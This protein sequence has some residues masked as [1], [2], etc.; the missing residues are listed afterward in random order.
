MP[1]LIHYGGLHGS[2]FIEKLKK[3]GFSVDL[4]GGGVY[5]LK[6][7]EKV[8]DDRHYTLDKLAGLPKD[9]LKKVKLSYIPSIEALDDSDILFRSLANMQSFE[10]FLE[11]LLLLQKDTI[12][13]SLYAVFQ[14][15]VNLKEGS[16]YGFEALCRGRISIT[17]LVEFAKPL[18]ETVDWTCREDALKKKAAFKIPADVKLFLNFFPE[19]LQNTEKA[20]KH[21]F[22]LLED[23]KISPNEIVVEITE[24]AGF[25]IE[26]LKKLVQ[27]WRALGMKIALDDVGRGED[28]LFRFLE[29]T[30]DIIKVD[31]AFV[32]DIHRNK[33]KRD[34][35]RYLI[36]LAH[37]NNMLVVVEGIEKPEE[38]RVV[39]ELDA[40]LVQG[41]LI[42]KPTTEPQRYLKENF[43]LKLKKWF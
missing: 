6:T 32:R 35:T 38:L 13:D 29:I 34:I 23:Y 37:T 20:S 17:Y 18:L 8:K 10:K 26:K 33:I 27:E 12:L 1:F 43:A 31:M 39:K 4:L 11:E 9:Y 7:A 30:P 5:I 3:L 19:S 25:D 28:S 16:L 42:G 14:P 41:W 24:Y 40:D 22:K 21:F 36:N 15:I 2:S